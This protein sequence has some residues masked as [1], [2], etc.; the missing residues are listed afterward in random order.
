MVVGLVVAA[1]LWPVR[2]ALAILS[3]TETVASTSTTT[4]LHPPTNLSA[5]AALLLRVNLSWTATTDPRATGYQVLR[6][7]ANGGPYSQVATVTSKATTTYQDTVPLPGIYYYV[8]RTY[9]DSW[10]SGNSNQAQVVAA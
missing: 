8:L 6:G 4:T 5:A 7:T 3:E 2:P 1:G 9:Y 10:T